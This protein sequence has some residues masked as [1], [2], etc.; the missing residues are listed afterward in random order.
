LALK[1]YLFIAD[2]THENK[3]LDQALAT[4]MPISK[5]KVRQLIVAGAVY[6]NGKR[7][8]IASK[9]LRKGARIQVFLDQEQLESGKSKDTPFTMSPEFV[10]YEDEMLLA[11]NKPA[12]LPTQ[13]TVDEARNNLFAAVKRYLGPNAYLGLHHRL[14]KDT[15]GVVLFT[16]REEANKGV[17]E[18]F[19][20]KEIQKT[21]V[22]VSYT[23]K[24]AFRNEW[25]TKNFL[26]PVGKGSRQHAVRSGGDSAQTDFVVLETKGAFVKV[27]ARPKTGRTHQI[28]VHLAGEGL[29]IW[30]DSVYGEEIPDDVMKAPR[31]MLHAW[32]LEF[33]H[34][35]KKTKVIIESP[36]PQEFRT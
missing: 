16:K 5:S 15:S 20:E 34:P 22:A 23:V 17:A 11:V 32:K 1:K 24:K 14:D 4:L 7:V 13:P 8:R 10:L 21:Y 36:I 3:R 35:V 28:R 31:M 2:S 25:T 29:P 12:G 27:E 9:M 33:V 26:A 19:S 6:L 30:G 18:L